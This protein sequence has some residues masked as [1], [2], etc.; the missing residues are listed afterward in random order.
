[1]EIAENLEISVNT[2]ERFLKENSTIHYVGLSKS[3][4][5]EIRE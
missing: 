3:G 4:Y 2:I 5:W 1:M